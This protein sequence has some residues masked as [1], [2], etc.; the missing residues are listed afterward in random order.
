[1]PY[2]DSNIKSRNLFRILTDNELDNKIIPEGG[3]VALLETFRK[4]GHSRHCSFCD[5]RGRDNVYDISQYIRCNSLTKSYRNILTKANRLHVVIVS[6][7]I[8]STD[9][10]YRED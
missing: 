9:I 2:I 5:I 1:M 3:G 10:F 6:R 7:T 8:F 4:S